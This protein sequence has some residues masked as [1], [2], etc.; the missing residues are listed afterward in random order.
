MENA[1][2]RYRL[3]LA[4]VGMGFIGPHQMRAARGVLSPRL[5]VDTCVPEQDPDR[6]DEFGIPK[7]LRFGFERRHVYRGLGELLA[8]EDV[9][10]AIIATRNNRHRADA[11]EC[12]EA[13]VAPVS[14][15]P[16][17]DTLENADVM[18]EAARKFGLSRT[19][20]LPSYTGHAAN[21]EA[22]HIVR[23]R[24]PVFR[25]GKAGYLQ[26]WLRKLLAT[27]TAAE[28]HDLAAWRKDPKQSGAGV[29]GDLIAHLLHETVFILGMPIVEA[30]AE[31]RWFVEGQASGQTE[32]TCFGQVRFENDG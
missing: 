19:C 16:L 13:G 3:Y 20:V 21:L 15:K 18:L 27:M 2:A 26:K 14:E 6:F 24:K 5:D 25:H 17:S 22:R 1:A 8:N 10:G 9:D 11:L 12:M 4:L 31:R 30:R 23:T 29:T 32:D 28:G 7:A